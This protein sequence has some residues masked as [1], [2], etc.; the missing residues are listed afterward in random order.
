MRDGPAQKRCVIFAI[1]TY[2]CSIHAE[3]VGAIIVAGRELQ[4]AGVEWGLIYQGGSSIVSKA[5]NALVEIFL[6][7]KHAT[8]LVFLDSDIVFRPE[9]LLKLVAWGDFKD[10]VAGA[11]RLKTDDYVRFSVLMS[12]KD[13]GTIVIDPETNRLFGIDG[14]GAGFMLIKRHV[15]E[16]MKSKLKLSSY[17]DTDVTG[18]EKAVDVTAFFHFGID[19]DDHQYIGEDIYFC[20][21]AKEAGFDLWIDPSIEISHVGPKGYTGKFSD[22]VSTIPTPKDEK[23]KEIA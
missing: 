14:V 13:D 3:T 18:D 12:K 22:L 8:D 15:F 2:D 19:E 1:P 10:V 11:Y 9:E 21:K 20:R 5:R 7:M 23:I 6:G 17:F 16:V 4:K